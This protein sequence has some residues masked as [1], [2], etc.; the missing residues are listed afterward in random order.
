MPSSLNDDKL[1][2]MLTVNE[3]AHLLNIHPGTV[4]RWEKDGHL[5]SC[6]IGPRGNIRFQREDILKLMST[7]SN[8]PSA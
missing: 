5:K 6:R 1:S 7:K 8:K 3:V 2:R 4:R